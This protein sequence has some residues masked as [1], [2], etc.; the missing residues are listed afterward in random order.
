[1]GNPHPLIQG[2]DVEDDVCVGEGC[3][4]WYPCRSTGVNN[5]CDVFLRIDFHG[6]RLSGHDQ[7]ARP[8][9]A[10]HDGQS[11]PDDCTDLDISAVKNHIP[12]ARR[13]AGLSLIELMVS[14]VI[15]LFLLAGTISIFI[16]NKQSYYAQ[17]DSS[18]V[19]ETGRFAMDMILRDIR[20][21]GY[22]GCMDSMSDVHNVLN[23]SGV[24]GNLLNTNRAVEGLDESSGKWLPYNVAPTQIS[25]MP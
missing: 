4:F 9:D 3:A 14:I 17:D 21:A 25:V 16:S 18:R 6:G 15:G 7:L 5:G 11:D 24:Q 20:M 10:C 19:Q 12:M 2:S 23:A 13:Q 1:M 22:F 8:I